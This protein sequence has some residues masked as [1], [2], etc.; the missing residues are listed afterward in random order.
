[1]TKLAYI[2]GYGHS[3]S[4]LLE[5]L[6]ASSPEVVAC[7]EVVSVPRERGRKRKCPC[8]SLAK[9]CPVWGPLQASPSALAGLSHAELTLTL[10][11]R[12]RSGHVL[13]V[14]SSKTAWRSIGVPFRLRR[15]LG[16]D[17][18][19]VHMVRDPRAVCWSAV[20]KARRQGKPPRT[21][22]RCMI[23]ALGWSVANLACELFGCR[24]P[25]AY[26]RLRYED[27][28]ESP[29][30]AM[31]ALFARLLPGA[32]WRPEEIGSGNNRHQLY[33]NRMR[34][35]ALSLADIKQDLAWQRDMAGAYRALVAALTFPL[36]RYYGYP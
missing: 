30:P 33:G 10:L 14:D 22:L 17:F 8:G 18:H 16:S 12:L 25:D 31:R 6:L 36:R 24:Y 4:T 9:D 3:G 32:L 26:T 19:L 27:L 20:K 21:G 35:Q 13:M 15:E 5:Y 34:S 28:T 23:A 7:G 11:E 29:V 2:G 1:M